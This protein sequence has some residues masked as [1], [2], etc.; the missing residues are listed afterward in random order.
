MRVCS[1]IYTW[2]FI[3]MVKYT[4]ED[5]PA[6]EKLGG[7]GGGSYKRMVG[8]EGMNVREKPINNIVRGM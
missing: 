5:K 6:G 4:R 7:V 1:A 3:Y 8:E 2:A